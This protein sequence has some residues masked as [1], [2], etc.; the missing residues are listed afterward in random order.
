MNSP[1]VDFSH[2]FFC[3]FELK[4]TLIIV[5]LFQRRKWFCHHRFRMLF[6]QNKHLLSI[7]HLLYLKIGF[8]SAISV[9][10]PKMVDFILERT[11]LIIADNTFADFPSYLWPKL[12]IYNHSVS[13]RQAKRR[14]ASEPGKAIN[15]AFALFF[16]FLFF[17]FF[18]FF[19]VFIVVLRTCSLFLERIL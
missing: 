12:E 10:C 13:Y 8:Y 4:W 18:F 9:C 16:F 7:S 14:K 11:L 19:L 2:H 1:E 15:R 3:M 6:H 17:F 5:Y